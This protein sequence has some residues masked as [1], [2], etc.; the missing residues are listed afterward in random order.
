MASIRESI[1]TVDGILTFLD[2]LDRLHDLIHLRME[3]AERSK[4]GED[5][6]PLQS[7]VVLNGLLLL[8]DEGR[9]AISFRDGIVMTE[10]LAKASVVMDFKEF[11]RRFRKVKFMRINPNKIPMEK[12]KCPLCDKGWDTSTLRHAIFA[13]STESIPL[14]PYA[15]MPLVDVLSE[16]ERRT[17]THFFTQS[18]LNENRERVEPSLGL[19]V[20]PGMLGQFETLRFMH[21]Q[22]VQARNAR[23]SGMYPAHVNRHPGA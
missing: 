8:M 9:I 7:W 15:G 5:L 23:A 6:P 17:G 22:C 21:P 11:R 4:Q 3:Y 16:L 18:I 12:C 20:R 10:G 2:S 14:N 19:Q 13:S 1:D